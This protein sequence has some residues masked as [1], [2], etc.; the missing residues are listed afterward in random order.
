MEELAGKVAVITGGGGGIGLATGRILAGEGMRVVLADVNEDRLDAAVKSCRDDG[1]DITGLAADVSKFES[2]RH[3]ADS[4][5]RSHG[6]VHLLHLNAGIGSMASFF[7]EDTEPWNRAVGVNLMGIVWGIK[8]FVPKM[9]EAGED[10]L[11]LATSSGAG[12]EGTMYTSPGYAATK[13][14]VLSLM[15]CLFGQL[16]DRG[17]RLQ[18]GVVFPPLTAT[19]L[20]GNPE[21]MKMVEGHLQSSGVPAVLVQPEDVARMI[22]DGIK[23]DRFF[24][25]CGKRE[26]D[27]FFAGAHPDEFFRWS[28]QMIRGR[29][30]AQLSDGNPG[31]Y[32]W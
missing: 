17:S 20:S 29:A 21:T 5:F 10:G 31:S 7:D 22:L 16:R 12:A 2:M 18:A 14:A 24:I 28:E 11:V 8:A 9:M 32:L 6:R 13:I 3:L 23:Q 4:V 1:L 26:N 30:D 25:R 15:E 27:A 19:N